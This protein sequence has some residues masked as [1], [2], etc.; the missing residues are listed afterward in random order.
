M[1]EQK[2]KGKTL[3]EVQQLLADDFLVWLRVSNVQDEDATTGT[4]SVDY[5]TIYA[6]R[7]PPTKPQ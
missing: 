2:V 6:S 1:S 3:A 4:V 5:D 7:K